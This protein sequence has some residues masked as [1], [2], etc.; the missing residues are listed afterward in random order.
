MI[1]GGWII[2]HRR[3]WITVYVLCCNALVNL[4]VILMTCTC[5]A[6]IIC[7]V[8]CSTVIL[9]TQHVIYFYGETPLVNCGPQSFL[10]HSYYHLL[11]TS[12]I[13]F[14]ANK[15][16]L[17]HDMFNPLFVATS[18]IDNLTASW[19]KVLWLCCVHV[20]RCCWCQSY[21][22]IGAINKLSEPSPKPASINLRKWFLSPTGSIKPWFHNRGK[23][24][25]VLII[26][27]SW[28][29]QLGG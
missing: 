18:E 29:S 8:N 26:P 25:A 4:I 20:P 3:S 5:I 27:S 22:Q 14:L 15:Y 12:I 17:P 11:S 19:G 1:S 16:F 23:L 13:Y 21:A 7:S 6:C 24:T 10:L 9:F 2:S 28:G